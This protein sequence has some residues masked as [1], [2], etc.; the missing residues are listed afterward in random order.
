MGPQA[1]WHVIGHA[2]RP[3]AMIAFYGTLQG[4]R[5]GPCRISGLFAHP[6]EHERAAHHVTNLAGTPPVNA[7]RLY[8]GQDWRDIRTLCRLEG[9]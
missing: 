4:I 6:S 8:P 9:S 2:H 7:V 1:P 3:T 5:S